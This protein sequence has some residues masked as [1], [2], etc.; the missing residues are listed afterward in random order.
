M[1]ATDIETAAIWYASADKGA[2]YYTLGI[3]EHI[4]G[5]DN[6]M[7][8][9]NLALMTGHVGR[10]GT[11]INPMRG[12][13]NVQGAG[14]MGASPNN[15]P[16]FQKVTD[17]AVQ[18]K[19]E[20]AWGRKVSLEIGPT[21]VTALEEGG[22]EFRAMLIDGENTLVSD[23]DVNLVRKSLEALD[24]LVVID[25]FLTETAELADVVL[26]ATSWAETDGTLREHRAPGPAGARGRAP[27]GRGE[28]RLVDRGP[29][30]PASR[31][32]G[33]RLEGRRGGLR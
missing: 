17:P 3:T 28:A 21:K 33:V 14:D 26:P 6:V 30:R 10:E 4:S 1:P 9:S 19:F 7:S 31:F 2:I 13:N 20:A 16:G 29:T 23:P 18:A 12:Q 5:V 25:L 27:S 11:G 32:P 24:H 15:Y 8:L 22:R